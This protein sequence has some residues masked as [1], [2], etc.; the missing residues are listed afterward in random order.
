MNVINADSVVL[1]EDRQ[2]SAMLLSLHVCLRVWGGR[3]GTMHML[4]RYSDN[5]RNV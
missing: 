3:R 2:L 1:S 4:A 5:P